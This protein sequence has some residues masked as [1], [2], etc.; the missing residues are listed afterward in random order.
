M[1]CYEDDI[2]LAEKILCDLRQTDGT[3]GVAFLQIKYRLGYAK[4]ARIVEYFLD[5]GY[6]E[7]GNFGSVILTDLSGE[8]RQCDLSYHIVVENSLCQK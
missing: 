7:K 3:F 8:E 2:A 4:A 5:N 6:A 1:K